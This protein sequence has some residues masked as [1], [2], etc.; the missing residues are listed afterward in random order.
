MKRILVG[1]AAVACACALA[2][3]YPNGTPLYVTDLVPACASCH[4][5][6][7]PDSMPELPP[8]R[9][10]MELAENKH[11]GA[12]RGGVFPIYSELSQEQKEALVQEVEAF[13]AEAKVIV[14]VPPGAQ[15]G[16]EFEVTVKYSGG[17]GPVVGLML[18]DR[19]LRYQARPIQSAGWDVRD[20]SA[21]TAGGRDAAEWFARRVEPKD[22]TLNFVLVPAGRPAEGPPPSG[23]V[24]YRL[25]APPDGGTYPVTAVFLYGTENT[26]RGGF[27]QRPS[28]RI[29]FSNTH[30][31]VVK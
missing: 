20:V 26:D 27:F 19:P 5:V 10:S 24:V 4:S 18:V 25:R 22:A 14:D 7:E 13:D 9:A 15:A 23:T 29:L 17:N 21:K 16:E 3:A 11:I 2:H 8:E 30:E 31:V 6:F 1:A 28:G 12:V